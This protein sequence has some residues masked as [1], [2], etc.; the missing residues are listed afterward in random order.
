MLLVAE[1]LQLSFL[2][3]SLTP[4]EAQSRTTDYPHVSEIIRDLSNRVIN[5]GKRQRVD[6]LSPAEQTQ[7]SYYTEAGFIWEMV[8]EREFKVRQGSRRERE[9]PT[10]RLTQNE[11]V[12]DGIAMTPDATRLDELITLEE[13]KATYKSEGKLKNADDLTAYF[14]EWDCQI[15][16]YLN[17]IG[18]L[19]ADLFVLWLCGNYAPMKPKAMRYHLTYTEEEVRQ[20]WRMLTQ[21]AERMRKEGRASDQEAGR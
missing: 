16:A 7:M 13:Y 6:Q 2:D 8:L 17:A 4:K 14:W 18:S 12:V 5:P 9:C 20:R 21:H 15:P 1:P 19:E 11:Y 3:A 10:V